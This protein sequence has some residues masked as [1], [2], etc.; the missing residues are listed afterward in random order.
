MA[1][2]NANS[3]DTI[4]MYDNRDTQ[5]QWSV[6]VSTSHIPGMDNAAGSG[7]H[8]TAGRHRLRCAS[9]VLGAFLTMHCRVAASALTG[10]FFLF[11]MFLVAATAGLANPLRHFE[12]YLGQWSISGPGR[13]FRIL[14]ILDGLGIAICL[15]TLV[16]AINCCTIA[17]ISTI[18]V[19]YSISD[20]KLPFTHCRDFDLKP[21]D[22]ILKDVSS[23]SSKESRF[24]LSIGEFDEDYNEKYIDDMH[25]SEFGWRNFSVLRFGFPKHYRKETYKIQMCNEKYGS[26]YP[27]LYSTPAYNFFYVEVVSYR[28]DYNFGQFNM[29]L[30][31]SLIFI[32]TIMWALLIAERVSH[33]RLIWNNVYTWLLA[34]PWI[35][36]VLLVITAFIHL[37]SMPKSLRKV[38]RIGV[39]E[40][41][42]G[43]ADA[44]E[45]ALYIHSA[46]SGTELI[47]GKGL[48]HYANGHIDPH[49][50]GENVWHS[51]LLLLLTGLNTGGAALCALVDYIQ[52]NTKA[53]YNMYESTL[54]IIP[55]YSK[56]VS[57]NNYSHFMSTVVFSGLAISYMTVAYLSLKTALHTIF[58]YKVKL[59]FAEQVVVAALILCCMSLSLLYAT[60][61]GIALL[62]SVD[63]IMT[64]LT[65][66]L[67]CLFELVAMI[68]V[69]RSH[70]FISDMNIATE[71]NAC[72]NRIDAQW[73]IIPFITFVVL[74]M[75]ATALT[76]AEMPQVFMYLAL[77]PLIGV[78][79]C[80]PI[81]AGVN[82]Y[83][84]YKSQNVR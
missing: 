20:S 47:H 54:W 39:K 71:E 52:P 62:E 56:C 7:S 13:A 50:N 15:N 17:A 49:L 74:V 44:L 69:Y 60:T 19:V 28:T 84:F 42:A 26:G 82:A 30:V 32:W 24:S 48:N 80:L 66:P 58:E 36:S 23:V 72:S 14:P 79:L 43:I 77:A 16:R 5:S 9:L 3:R 38:Y 81:R 37:V 45:I 33:G 29:P 67:I 64:G 75:K 10:G 78:I 63:S 41:M 40:I 57:I 18:Y 6:V 1:S 53:V 2:R 34:I 61:G 76:S 8:G 51:G 73:Q 59:V 31:L 4:L 11:I 21:Y 46:S 65:M 70:D 55:M 27:T 35:W 83:K 25:T 22:P 12:V 68:Y